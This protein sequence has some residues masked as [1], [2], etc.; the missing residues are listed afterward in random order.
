M[1][2]AHDVQR[3]INGQWWHG[4]CL[5]AYEDHHETLKRIARLLRKTGIPAGVVTLPDTGYF[6]Y[7]KRSVLIS[8]RLMHPD[9]LTPTQ[10]RLQNIMLELDR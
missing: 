1:T 6:G 4:Q 3:Y 8:P 5:V 9:S 10:R 7:V 2:Y